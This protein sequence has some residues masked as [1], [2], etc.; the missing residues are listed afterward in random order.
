M[1]DPAK[2]RA[3]YDDL[4]ALPEHVIGEIIDGVLYTQSRPAAPHTVASSVLFSDLSGPFYR[5]RGPGGWV[6]LFEPELH[7]HGNVVVP[8]VAGWRRSRMP[9]I[10]EATAFELAP[11]WVCEVLSPN[12]AAHDRAKKL[13]L[14]AREK[15]QHAWLVD[16]AARTLEAF[17]L[18][19]ERWLL[20]GAWAHDARV[21][22]EPFDA[23]EL[24]LAALCS[25]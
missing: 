24:E 12:N 9:E 18:E 19:G 15:V 20:L 23:I 25:R 16:P 11:D 7:L 10:P 14:Y 3:T 21:R 2:R 22:V 8:D 13:P 4:L 1:G 17:A 5:G 6:I